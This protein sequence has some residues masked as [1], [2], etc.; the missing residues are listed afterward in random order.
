[1][2]EAE[3]L[4]ATDPIPLLEFLRDRASDRKLRLF[5]LACSR[6]ALS[7][8]RIAWTV[9]AIEANEQYADEQVSTDS[10]NR[11]SDFV[12]LAI[13]TA[14]QFADTEAWNTVVN[15][16]NPDYAVEIATQNAARAAEGVAHCD[17]VRELFGNPFHS[18]SHDPAWRTEAVVGLAA[19]VYADR[20]FDR[21]PVLADALEDAG[22]ADADILTHCRGP[23]PHVRGCWVVDLLLGKS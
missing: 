7:H 4:M 23:G 5:A 22:C 8:G 21:L 11:D 2:T 10:T 16:A 13:E 14:R 6:R 17:L 19:G 20:A 3:W 12:T 15:A 9:S 1:M 18:I